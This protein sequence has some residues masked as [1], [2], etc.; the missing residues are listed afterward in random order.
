RGLAPLELVMGLPAL[1][2]TMALI[3]NFGAA[4][5]WKVRGTVAARDAAWRT[6]Y[7]RQG[8][9][10]AFPALSNW[11]AP[12][13]TTAG[14]SGTFPQVDNSMLLQPV[15]RGPVLAGGQV[16]VQVNENLL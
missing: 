3:W 1:L 13:T 14:S 10:Q 9:S 5:C 7:D 4:A 16:S 15:A 6:R 12:A 2:F 8:R 11:P